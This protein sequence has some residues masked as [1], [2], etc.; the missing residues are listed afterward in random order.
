MKFTEDFI[1]T[2]RKFSL[3]NP[4]MYFVPGKVQTT[5]IGTKGTN[6]T[7]FF[8]RAFT[9]IEIDQPFGIGDLS[10]FLSALKIFKEPEVE[11]I[12]NKFLE[13]HEED[14]FHNVT[15]IQY[16][17]TNPTF[18]VYK[19]EP[20]KIQK[21]NGIEFQF[22]KTHLDTIKN[23]YGVF[24]S[25]HIYFQG[26]DKMIYAGVNNFENPTSDLGSIQIG[27]Y[28]RPDFKAVI[29]APMFKVDSGDHQ[30]IINSKGLVYL[31]NYDNGT[32][33]FIPVEKKLSE[34]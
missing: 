29:S 1:N 9:D 2:L 4:N 34:L 18:L 17:L 3:I 8:A 14:K 10:R 26:K 13:I 19:Q 33:Y 24:G 11:V 7:S 12:D 16:T 21:M 25:P 28:E 30:I 6:S 15:K 22:L 27:T 23:M 5:M 32:E 20:D 31:K